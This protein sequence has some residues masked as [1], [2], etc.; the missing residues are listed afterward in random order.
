[1]Q[2]GADDLVV[3]INAIL[4]C[5]AT[6]RLWCFGA[7]KSGQLGKYQNG[8][9]ERRIKE[10]GRMARAMMY[11]SDAPDL[12]SVYGLLQAVDIL[13]VLPT[14]ANAIASTSGF[15]P[16]FLYYGS[17]PPLVEYYPFGSYCT[18]HLDDDHIDPLVRAAQ[19]IYLYRAHHLL[20]KGHVLWE[21]RASGKG[22][23]LIVPSAARGLPQLN[24]PRMTQHMFQRHAGTFRNNATASCSTL[25]SGRQNPGC[26]KKQKVE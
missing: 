12:A 3:L 16:H 2:Y 17:A 20:S 25:L 18:V 15:S 13:N 6:S 21:Y 9:V 22:R 10:L 14:T 5:R 11:T 26:Q 24:L 7:W 1:M 4:F 8:V 23:R 19:C